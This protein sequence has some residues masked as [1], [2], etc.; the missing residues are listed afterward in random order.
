MTWKSTQYIHVDKWVESVQW[1]K[2][3]E[4]WTQFVFCL[5][6]QCSY[7]DVWSKKNVSWFEMVCTRCRQNPNDFIVYLFVCI[8]CPSWDIWRTCCHYMEI[9]GLFMYIWKRHGATQSYIQSKNYKVWRIGKS[10]GVL[11]WVLLLEVFIH[12]IF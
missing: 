4:H 9:C 5:H 3:S 12:K 2:N 11:H 1:K 7:N 6:I 8:N 10:T